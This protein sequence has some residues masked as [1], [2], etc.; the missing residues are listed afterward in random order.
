MNYKKNEVEA[1]R[2][3]FEIWSQRNVLFAMGEPSV[4]QMFEPAVAARICGLDYEYQ[5]HIEA[6]S[7]S[8]SGFEAAGLLDRANATITISTH[9]SYE[10]QRFTGGH[11]IGHLVL[12]PWIGDGTAH[13]DRSVIDGI[14]NISR[15]L[16]EREA[17]YFA[18][19]FLAPSKLVAQE[20]GLRF[21]R[22][23]IFLSETL[24]FHLGGKQ[25]RLLMT[26]PPGSLNFA[27]AL[28]G[29]RS[30]DGRNFKSLSEHFGISVSAMAIRLH[31]VGLIAS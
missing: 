27:A 12:H 21:G 31:E 2:L 30:L 24:A 6:A 3:Q 8:P 16:I 1:R 25:E 7:G 9:F 28:S 10:M 20:F 18:A 22:A 29:A 26:S 17:D 5:I 19:C 13:R 15:P 11:E 23:P 14:L 4:R